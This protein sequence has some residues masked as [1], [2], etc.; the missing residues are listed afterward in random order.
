MVVYNH[1][2][3]E[4]SLDAALQ[5]ADWL[6]FIDN[7]SNPAVTDRL[8]AY[9]GARSSRAELIVAGGNVGLSRG[10][11]LGVKRAL[12]LGVIWI[13]LVDHDAIFDADLLPDLRTAWKRLESAGESVGVVV[14]IVS[15]DRRVLGSSLGF[16]SATTPL[17]T[18]ITSG[19]LTTVPLFEAVGGFDER[20]FV[21]GSDLDLTLRLRALGRGVFQLNRVL[22]VQQFEDKPLLSGPLYRLLSLLIRFRSLLRVRM[23]NCNIYRTTLS[24]YPVDRETRLVE[25]LQRVG[26]ETPSGR[27]LAWLIRSLNAA[28]KVAIGVAVRLSPSPT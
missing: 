21:D 27:G 24:I 25:A 16:R 8:R 14:P 2:P 1:F 7:S 18:S 5:T 10:Y 23:G 20:I 3:D 11:N 28:E 17:K 15:D 12:D 9:V 19:M 6:L 13:L 26:S 22:V 4:P